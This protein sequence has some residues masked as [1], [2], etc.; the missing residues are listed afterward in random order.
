MYHKSNYHQKTMQYQNEEENRKQEERREVITLQQEEKVLIVK[1]TSYTSCY[2]H[3][4]KHF[5]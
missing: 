4:S 1:H 3:L 5:L 2:K